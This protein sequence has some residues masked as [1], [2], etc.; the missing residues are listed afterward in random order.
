MPTLYRTYED[1]SY[2]RLQKLIGAHAQNLPHSVFLNF[3]NKI[4]KRD[5]WAGMG[6]NGVGGLQPV[7][8]ADLS[9]SKGGETIQAGNG[10]FIGECFW[11][12]GYGNIY[13][14]QLWITVGYG[15]SIEYIIYPGYQKHWH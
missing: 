15:Y 2:Q 11:T 10:P 13:W 3:A 14:T 5:K 12:A 9:R 6:A 4:Y 7:S 1:E 8:T